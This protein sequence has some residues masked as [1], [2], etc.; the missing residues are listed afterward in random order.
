MAS[1][2]LDAKSIVFINYFQTCHT[3]N[4]EY[5]ADLLRQLRTGIKT[6]RKTFENKYRLNELYIGQILQ[7]SDSNRL[8]LSNPIN[9]TT[10]HN[11]MATL[12]QPNEKLV[13]IKNNNEK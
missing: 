8:L 6:K 3:I 5:Y 13:E 7:V 2:L 12:R 11:Y 1:V 4:E 9:L 10:S